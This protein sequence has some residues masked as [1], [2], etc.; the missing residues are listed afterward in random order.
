SAVRAFEL[1][2]AHAPVELKHLNLTA[3]DAQRYQRL[4]GHMIFPSPALRAPPAVLRANRLAQDG[5]WR[6]GISGDFPIALAAVSRPDD[7][8]LVRQLLAA[9]TYWRHNGLRVDLVVLN[10]KPS[11]YY[12]EFVQ[13][14][15]HAVRA[16]PARDVID[17]PGGVFVR[18]ADAMTEDERVLLRT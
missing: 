17:R 10:E 15:L 1:A 2:W 3:A 7:L 11:T 8:P 5:L 13:Q 9:H 4:A 14:I 18:R 16:T 6:H 12:D